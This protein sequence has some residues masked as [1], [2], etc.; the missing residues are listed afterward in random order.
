MFENNIIYLQPES[1]GC[2]DERFLTASALTSPVMFLEQY[3]NVSNKKV[4]YITN[5]DRKGKIEIT[6]NFA[7]Y[8]GEYIF[9]YRIF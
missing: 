7:N 4:N 5:D 8:K 1:Q 9:V 3:A 2:G 6:C